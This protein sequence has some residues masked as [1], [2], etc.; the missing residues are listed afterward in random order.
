M[1]IERAFELAIFSLKQGEVPVGCV[2]VDTET[3]EIIGEGRNRPMES[4][5]AT[6]HAELEALLD[7]LKKTRR[8]NIDVYV[9]VEPCIMCA[10]AL[11]HFFEIKR[12]FFGCFN[13]RFGGCGSAISVSSAVFDGWYVFESIQ[14]KEKE[15]KAINLLRSFYVQ[16]NK[17]APH[18]KKKER[19]IFKKFNV[20]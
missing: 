8:K 16:E 2:L 18:P 10:A 3:N 5:D 9:T 19:R 7:Y 20:D 14:L 1:F 11:K 12:V 17:R 15:E 6:K 13:E 4:N